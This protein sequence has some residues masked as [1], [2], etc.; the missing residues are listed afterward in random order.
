MKLSSSLKRF[1]LFVVFVLFMASPVFSGVV[2]GDEDTPSFGFLAYLSKDD[3]AEIEFRLE[4]VYAQKASIEIPIGNEYG[5]YQLFS[6]IKMG[7]QWK[8]EA[9]SNNSPI[10]N[11]NVNVKLEKGKVNVLKMNRRKNKIY[12]SI[13]DERAAVI[14]VSSPTVIVKVKA[15][16]LKMQYRW[17]KRNFKE[18]TAMERV[19]IPGGMYRNSK[20]YHQL[21]DGEKVR[22]Y[23]KPLHINPDPEFK[24]SVMF[25]VDN[26]GVWFVN[27]KKGSFRALLKHYN[28]LQKES[29]QLFPIKKGWNYV[30]IVRK[31]DS[32]T[33]Y[34][35]G[36]KVF[37]IIHNP[38]KPREFG[39][40][41]HRRIVGYTLLIR[42]E[43]VVVKSGKGGSID[44][45]IDV[46]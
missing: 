18:K 20:Y 24:N 1:F 36:K 11:G 34:F 3:S 39:W 40:F 30:D 29:P 25:Y 41:V 2:L 10:N 22:L 4:D 32:L 44:K 26:M 16:G 42:S 23:I 7:K 17:K 38:V 31:G 45:W 27:N 28:S 13:N 12:F 14:P 21:F 5:D 8:V 43:K 6:I 35:N 9:H 33:W 46:K 37:N 15:V 19:D